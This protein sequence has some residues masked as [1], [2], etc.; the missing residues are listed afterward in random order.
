V[1]RVR[2]RLLGMTRVREPVTRLLRRLVFSPRSP[3]YS[4]ALVGLNLPRDFV[5]DAY[6]YLHA[7]VQQSLMTGS[8]HFLL[9]G[10]REGRNYFQRVCDVPI[11]MNPLSGVNLNRYQAEN[12]LPSDASPLSHYLL[13]GQ[14]RGPWTVEKIAKQ[15]SATAEGLPHSVIHFHCFHVDLLDEFLAAA[16]AVISLPT[17]ELVVTFSD[18]NAGKYIKAR[19]SQTGTDFRAVEV[20]NR[21]RNFGALRELIYSTDFKHVDLWGHF[22]SKSSPHL[23]SSF[24]E[25]WRTFIYSSLLD[26]GPDRIGYQD[27]LLQLTKDPKL[28]IAFPDDPHEFGWGENYKMGAAIGKEMGF[29]VS[30]AAPKFPVGGMFVAKRALLEGLYEGASRFTAG[31]DEP[32]AQDGTVWHAFERLLGVVPEHLGMRAAVNRGQAGQYFWLRDTH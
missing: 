3:L 16:N 23:D 12:L 11:L 10:K 32:L 26:S 28:S 21:G 15:E 14:P 25:R 20:P 19:A 24:T 1:S 13:A 30:P 29:G 7:D 31:A 27:I 8:Q 22:H 5:E 6:V 17:N 4:R 18:H 9:Y 2:E